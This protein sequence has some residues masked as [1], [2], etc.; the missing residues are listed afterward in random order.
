MAK[1]YS[2]PEGFDPP[3][4]TGDDYRNNTWEQKENAYLERLAA[5]CRKQGTDPLLGEIVRWQRGDGYAQ[6]MVWNTRPLELIHLNIADGWQV[7][8]ALIRGLRVSDVR[9]MVERE[10]RMREFFSK[11]AEED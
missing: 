3:E 10:R 2:A 9:D 1:A 6:Y 8:D 4:I 7:E 11:K 5:E